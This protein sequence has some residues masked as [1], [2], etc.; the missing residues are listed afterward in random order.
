[1]LFEEY[2][3]WAAEEGEHPFLELVSGSPKRETRVV[4]DTTRQLQRAS[5]GAR[6]RRKLLWR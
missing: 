4:T 3:G 1:M 2:G 6:P 5:C